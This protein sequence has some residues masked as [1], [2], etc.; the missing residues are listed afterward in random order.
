MDTTQIHK[1]CARNVQAIARNVKIIN[2]VMNATQLLALKM[3][4][5]KLAQNVKLMNL[6]IVKTLVSNAKY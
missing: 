2:L 5:K 4:K 1:T 3:K 6:L